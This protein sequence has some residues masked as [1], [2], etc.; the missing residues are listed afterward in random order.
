MESF[1][2]V[3]THDYIYDSPSFNIKNIIQL[4]IH[5]CSLALDINTDAN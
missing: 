2:N 3:M 1:F 5:P 4:L